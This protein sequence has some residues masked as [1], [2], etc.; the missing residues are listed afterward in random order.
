VSVLFESCQSL[1]MLCDIADFLELIFFFRV[2][3]FKELLFKLLDM[4]PD[5]FEHPSD[6]K[7][8]IW[9]IINEDSLIACYLLHAILIFIRVV[10]IFTVAL[11][12]EVFSH[13]FLI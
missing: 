11:N 12:L 9:E 10:L 7:F 4:L 6:V 2:L 5:V 8:V 13:F 3:F 1:L